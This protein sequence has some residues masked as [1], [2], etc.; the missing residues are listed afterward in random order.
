MELLKDLT[1]GH[2]VNTYRTLKARVS[3]CKVC[4]ETLDADGQAIVWDL[5]GCAGDKCIVCGVRNSTEIMR[6][7]RFQRIRKVFVIHDRHIVERLKGLKNPTWDILTPRGW[8]S[9]SR[10]GIRDLLLEVGHIRQRRP[11]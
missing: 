11:S 4:L 6:T 7:I 10:Q 9:I 2:G 3:L 1:E 5:L 8:A